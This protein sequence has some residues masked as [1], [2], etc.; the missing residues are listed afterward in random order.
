VASLQ[1]VN[2]AKMTRKL[3]LRNVL[4]AII[5]MFCFYEHIREAQRRKTQ[6]DKKMERKRERRKD[7]TIRGMDG[8]GAVRKET[9]EEQ[10]MV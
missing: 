7:R 5:K 8:G 6:K 2:T 1:N 10:E 4:T 9:V 3:A